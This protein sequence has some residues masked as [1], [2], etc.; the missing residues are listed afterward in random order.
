MICPICGGHA[1]AVFRSPVLGKYD[2]QYFHCRTCEFLRTEDPYWLEEA[3]S[4]AIAPT[5]VGLVAR[6]IAISR[7]LSIL[8]YFLLGT[9]IRCVDVAG[10]YGMLCR[11]M[12]D[13]GFDYYWNDKFCKNIFASGHEAKGKDGYAVASFFEAIEHM[14]DPLKFCRDVVITFGVDTLVFTT[15]LYAGSPP[16]PE[17]WWYYSSET[18]Q[19]ISF[20]TRTTLQYIADSLGMQLCSHQN[21]H[22]LTKENIRPGLFSLLCSRWAGLVLPFYVRKRMLSRVEDDF[23][24]AQAHIRL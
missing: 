7:K 21:F 2:V 15:E 11:L 5:D 23:R 12:R 18:G 20:C 17:A 14:P 10:G 13:I 6:N 9:K 8:L 16:S 24:A 1:E 4:S 22:I 19:H 3:Y